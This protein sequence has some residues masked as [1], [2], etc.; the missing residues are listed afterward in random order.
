MSVLNRVAGVAGGIGGLG[1]GA[2][3]VGLQIIACG[4]PNTSLIIAVN[5]MTLVRTSST[6]LH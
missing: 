4:V 3:G 2:A 6:H 1:R 5:T